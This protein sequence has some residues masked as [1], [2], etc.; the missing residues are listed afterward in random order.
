MRKIVLLGLGAKKGL[1]IH[2]LGRK[3]VDLVGR[4][5]RRLLRRDTDPLMLGYT[6]DLLQGWKTDLHKPD[7]INMKMGI[8]SDLV[9]TWQECHLGLS[10]GHC[11]S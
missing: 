11:R 8:D 10:P 4:E 3:G 7:K 9:E 1:W 6:Q 2:L 5:V